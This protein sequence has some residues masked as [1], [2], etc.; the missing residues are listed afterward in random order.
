VANKGCATAIPRKV[1]RDDKKFLRAQ[2]AA[3][4]V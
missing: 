3:T 1:A 2:R 4:R